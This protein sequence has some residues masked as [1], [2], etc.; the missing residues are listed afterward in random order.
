[1]SLSMV[2]AFVKPLLPMA[3][4]KAREKKENIQLLDDEIDTIILL[5][6]V[7]G[8]AYGSIATINSQ[9]HI[10]RQLL[11]EEISEFL[12]NVKLS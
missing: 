12:K 5:Y 4:K 8:V 6:E 10:K 9:N 3:I 11:T 1:M 2:L 7:D